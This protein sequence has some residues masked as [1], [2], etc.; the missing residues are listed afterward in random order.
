MS[1][2]ISI[3]TPAAEP[4]SATEKTFTQADVDAIVGKR[5]AKAMKGMPTEDE[6]SAFRNWRENQDTSAATI[7]SL[8]RERDTAVSQVS[9]LQSEI[10]QMKRNSY[11]L[12]KGLTGDDA[13]FVAFKAEK[14]VDEKTTFEQAVDR[15]VE[16]RKQKPVFNWTAP[17][18]DGTK[19]NNVNETMNALIRRAR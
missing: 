10:D 14:M 9:T 13:E 18:G 3:S 19:Q 8:T 4:V 11:I 12:S 1:E 15:I 6:L 2:T 5:L 7:A 17:V 16:E